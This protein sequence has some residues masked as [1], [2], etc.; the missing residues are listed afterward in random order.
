MRF[1]PAHRAYSLIFYRSY[2]SQKTKNQATFILKKSAEKKKEKE[3][4]KR[5][6]KNVLTS[7]C[8]MV[9]ALVRAF[10]FKQL[11][12]YFIEKASYSC[13]SHTLRFSYENT[14]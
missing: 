2:F 13:R 10:E 11:V 8:E 12:H 1:I 9:Q 14:K 4:R 7:Y 3:N 5:R 6:E